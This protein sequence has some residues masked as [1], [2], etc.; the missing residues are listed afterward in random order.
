VYLFTVQVFQPFCMFQNLHKILK[1]IIK[2][3]KMHKLLHWSDSPVVF[4][5]G[6]GAFCGE[7]ISVCPRL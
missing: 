5:S 6:L 7:S 3:I 2:R 4:T 1:K